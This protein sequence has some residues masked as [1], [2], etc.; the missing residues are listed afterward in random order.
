MAGVYLAQNQKTHVDVLK[1]IRAA[2]VTFSPG[3][4]TKMH[5]HDHEQILYILSGKGIVATEREENVALPGMIFLI[6]PGENHWHG[7][8]EES[9]FSHLFVFNIAT[10]TTF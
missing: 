10:E 6:Q 1:E 4:K 9:S 7:A 5:I 3:A 8:T 2:I